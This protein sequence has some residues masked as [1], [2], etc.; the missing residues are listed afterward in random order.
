MS[1]IS[2]TDLAGPPRSALRRIDP[3]V[4]A[5]TILGFA[6]A[7]FRLGTKSMWLDEAVS[8]DHAR[9]GLHGLWTVVSHTDPNMGLYYVLLHFWVRVFGYGEAAV[10]S[11]TVVL[12]GMA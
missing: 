1:Q 5:L 8:A 3:A 9:L 6:L 2:T 4:F 11:M 7:S 12:A 10:R